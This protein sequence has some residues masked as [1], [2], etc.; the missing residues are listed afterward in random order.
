MLR[1]L[2]TSRPPLIVNFFFHLLAFDIASS[3]QR[4][5]HCNVL[6]IALLFIA[7]LMQKHL[8]CRGNAQLIGDM[9]FSFLFCMTIYEKAIENLII[10]RL[11]V[12]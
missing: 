9:D 6:V 1:F 5:R 2:M 7:R 8:C 11:K 3:L 10:M 12:T 4:S